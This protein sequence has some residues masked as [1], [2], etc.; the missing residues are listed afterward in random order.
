MQTSGKEFS[1]QKEQYWQRL[2]GWCVPD[3]F[4]NR[5]DVSEW[6]SGKMTGEESER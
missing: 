2:C 1:R 3:M 4:K 6:V 5:K